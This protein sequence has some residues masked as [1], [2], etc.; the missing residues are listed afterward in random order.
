MIT[1]IEKIVR[2]S[3]PTLTDVLHDI[4]I[5]VEAIGA[6]STLITDG[7]LAQ[8]Q[9]DAVVVESRRGHFQ[10]HLPLHGLVS[11]ALH[12]LQ[13]DSIPV[14]IERLSMGRQY[15]IT[16]SGLKQA[17]ES[18]FQAGFLRFYVHGEAILKAL[19]GGDDNWN[20]DWR[21]AWA[22]RNAIAHDGKIDIRN[23]NKKPV[24]WDGLRFAHADNGHPVLAQDIGVADLVVLMIAMDQEL[25]KVAR[26]VKQP[27]DLKNE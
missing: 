20:P 8:K 18:S 3:S 22:I 1:R 10:V 2:A 26:T 17:I 15:S 12:E 14:Q 19:L 4:L 6:Y 7:V 25:R 11:S 27:V 5:C 24:E 9:S 23:P 16:T 21:F 13:L